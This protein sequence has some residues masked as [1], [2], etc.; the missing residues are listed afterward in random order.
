MAVQPRFARTGRAMVM[1]TLVSRVTGFVRMLALVAALGLGSRLFDA[2][3]VAN[4]TP[5]SIYELV[6]GGAL[7][8]VIVP[9]LVRAA[10]DEHTDGELF[11]QRLLSLVVYVL[12]VAST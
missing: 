9:L 2:Y 7:A 3:T 5:N 8:S 1:A 11:A 4:L 12:A 6:L 10:A